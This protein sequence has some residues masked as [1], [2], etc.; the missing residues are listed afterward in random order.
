MND[1]HGTTMVIR[2]KTTIRVPD[3]VDGEHVWRFMT[4]GCA[5]WKVVDPSLHE[6]ATPFPRTALG[7]LQRFAQDFWGGPDYTCAVREQ[8]GACITYDALYTVYFFFT[9]DFGTRKMVAVQ[10]NELVGGFGLRDDE[11]FTYVETCLYDDF[12][13]WAST[14]LSCEEDRVASGVGVKALS[15]TL[16]RE[17]PE[18]LG[19]LER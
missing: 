2:T 19:V 17:W 6:P 11:P 18:L 10:L 12:E 16:A 1:I 7:E 4:L 3:R 5:P 15:V 14:E 13:Q 8:Q 9:I